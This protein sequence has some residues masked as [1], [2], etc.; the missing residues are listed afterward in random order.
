MTAMTLAGRK[1]IAEG[2][3]A[4]IFEWEPG[5][6]L[7]LYRSQEWA[8][9]APVERA[10]MEAVRVAGGPAPAAGD[11]VEVDGRP[12]LVMERVQGIDMLTQ[13]GSRPWT[14]ASIG[15]ALAR[16]H[17][18]LHRSQ[19]PAELRQLNAALASY[20]ES[21]PGVPEELR[22]RALDTLAVLPQG[23][24][25]CHGDYHPGNVIIS[26]GRAVVIDWP[27]ATAGDPLAD[28]ARTIT[29]IRLGEPPPG[30][31]FVVSALLGIGRK[32]V[33]WRYRAAYAAAAPIDEARLRQWML[34]SAVARFGDDIPEERSKLLA[35]IDSL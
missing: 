28:V 16:A 15:S 32:V 20:I 23:D 7:K 10:A 31:P 25:V 26:D 21:A 35:L 30:T 5:T 13:A 27:N 29:L 12:G 24:R 4:E 9:N 33:L 18:A 8:R 22:R 19:A 3:E 6:V 17:L 14:I 1:K 2:R 34:V 11:V